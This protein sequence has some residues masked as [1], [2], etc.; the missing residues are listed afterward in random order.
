MLAKSNNVDVGQMLLPMK[1]VVR[2]TQKT[3]RP[4]VNAHHLHHLYRPSRRDDHQK[5][6][7]A[8]VRILSWQPLMVRMSLCRGSRPIPC[9]V[10]EG[11][12]PVRS[13]LVFLNMR[14]SFFD[15]H[16]PQPPISS[17]S[18]NHRTRPSQYRYLI[19]LLMLGGHWS[20]TRL[21]VLRTRRE[22]PPATR[23]HLALPLQRSLACSTPTV[24]R[25]YTSAQ[26]KYG[27][28]SPL[29]VC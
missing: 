14:A 24:G 22:S 25:S 5:F 19:M 16:R 17:S 9:G 29:S 20:P 15:V 12:V 18:T 8:T 2:R 28:V 23:H 1:W 6:C 21:P 27:W 26:L 13:R 10:R 11:T 4:V 3:P 7:C